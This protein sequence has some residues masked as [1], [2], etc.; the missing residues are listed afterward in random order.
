[1]RAFSVEVYPNTRGEVVIKQEMDCEELVV[2]IHPDQVPML[3]TW[4]KVTAEEAR[5]II[6]EED[7]KL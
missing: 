6:P 3:I 5:T 1:M 2:V 4:L 7:N